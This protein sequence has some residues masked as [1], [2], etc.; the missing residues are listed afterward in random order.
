MICKCTLIPKSDVHSFEFGVHPWDQLL[1]PAFHSLVASPPTGAEGRTGYGRSFSPSL[2]GID[3]PHAVLITACESPVT[4]DRLSCL[5]PHPPLSAWNMWHFHLIDTRTFE[6]YITGEFSPGLLVLAGLVTLLL[7]ILVIASNS[8][9]SLSF[10]P[11]P[12]ACVWV[13]TLVRITHFNSQMLL[14]GG[15]CI[16]HTF[17][18]PRI[19]ISFE[20]TCMSLYAGI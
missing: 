8:L 4:L 13:H 7:L 16:L 14:T 5:G 9:L 20:C 15:A 10:T 18:L 19:A 1:F 11:S 3:P 17:W 12:H 2:F 6:S